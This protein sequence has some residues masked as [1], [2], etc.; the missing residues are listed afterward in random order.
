L[1]GVVLPFFLL[2]TIAMHRAWAQSPPLDPIH[3]GMSK[4]E[5]A[6]YYSKDDARTYRTDI[7]E[8]WITFDHAEGNLPAMITFHIKDN[9]V[10]GWKVN[11][12]NEVVKEYLGEYC[13][14][15]FIQSSPKIYTA[16]QNALRRL[17]LNV[18]LS[19]TDRARPVLFTEFH[20]SGMGRFANSSEIYS[21]EDDAPSMMAGLTIIKLNMELEEAPDSTAIEGVILH[22]LAHRYLKHAQTRTNRN[23]CDQEREANRLVKSW[24]ADEEFARAQEVFGGKG[25]GICPEDPDSAP[26]GPAGKKQTATQNWTFGQKK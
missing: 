8:E 26:A 3:V 21:F 9:K 19:V 16:I 22:E 4:P 1:R 6:D 23:V 13:S 24:G 7:N 12:R 17:P 5:F 10:A 18:F 20:S 2:G 11:D 15:A 14:Q 25:G